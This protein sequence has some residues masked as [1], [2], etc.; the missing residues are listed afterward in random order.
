MPKD[1][2][3]IKKERG[4]KSIAF[5]YICKGQMKSKFFFQGHITSKA[6]II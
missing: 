2:K 3:S 1:T 4:K 5:P 6:K